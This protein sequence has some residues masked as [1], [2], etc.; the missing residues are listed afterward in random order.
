VE[1]DMIRLENISKYYHNEGIVTLGL[2]KINLEFNVGEFIALTGESG[3]GKS[4]LLNVISGIDSYEDGE[5]Y[6]NNEETSHYDENDWEG[7]RRDSVGFIFQNYN[8]IDSY[9]V[10][11]NVEVA[12]VIQGMDKVTRKAK[13]K[14]IIEKVGLTSHLKHRAS[15]LSG[16]Q[17][18]RLAIARALAKDTKIIVADEPI[19]NLDSESGEQ[20][21]KLLNEISKDK[22]VIVVTHNFQQAEPFVTR[23]VRLYAGEVVEDK[24]VKNV[25]KIE[26]KPVLK[27]AKTSKFSRLMTISSFNLISQP[28]KTSLLLL[29]CF[30]SI[31][32]IFFTYGSYLMKN[33]LEGIEYQ[34]INSTYNAYKERVVVARIDKLAMTEDDYN[35]FSSLRRV[36]SVIKEDLIIETEFET[37]LKDLIYNFNNKKYSGYLDLI[38]EYESEDIIG[39]LPENENEILISTSIF[40]YSGVEAYQDILNTDIYVNYSFSKSNYSQKFKIVGFHFSNLGNTKFYVTD[41]AR[42]N[43]NSEAKIIKANYQL[44]IGGDFENVSYNSIIIKKDNQLKENEIILPEGYKTDFIESSNISI[45]ENQMTL[46]DADFSDSDIKNNYT[47]FVFVSPEF[48]NQIKGDDYQYT[49]HLKDFNKADSL[50]KDLY[51]M[52]YYAFSPFQINF[53]LDGF[54]IIAAQFL[55]LITTLFLLIVV[56]LVSYLNIKTIMKSKKRDYTIL[57]TIGVKKSSIKQIISLEVVISYLSAYLLFLITFI[58]LYIYDPIYF[59]SFRK[60][61]KIIDYF[62]LG[63]INLIIAIFISRRFNKLLTK[64]NLL[65]DLRLGE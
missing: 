20:I 56:F 65:S 1:G 8:L 12:L 29:I 58:I 49:I 59:E 5:F 48:F 50:V 31:I 41:E 64:K 51:K 24:R 25:E 37:F 13:A 36:K 2:R 62:I 21:L 11:K 30:V 7:Y 39:R 35:Q 46:V 4:T 55:S 40:T 26:D 43:F 27:A 34:N 16:G 53:S 33:N 22:L 3:S 63:L 57:R 23:K 52:G 15:K 6:I 32:F 61:Y 9:T 19:G 28:R 45:G 18:Q 44:F 38:G 47:R 17:K 14:E 10:M 42:E 54:Q 60:Q